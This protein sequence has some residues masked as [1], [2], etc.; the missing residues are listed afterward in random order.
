MKGSVYMRAVVRID[1]DLRHGDR[2]TLGSVE[3]SCDAGPQGI[4]SEIRHRFIHRKRDADINPFRFSHCGFLLRNFRNVG[5]SVDLF[6]R[7]QL[8]YCRF[9]NKLEK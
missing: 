3:D 9:P 8:K 2:I 6:S 4:G 1:I 7:F 5:D